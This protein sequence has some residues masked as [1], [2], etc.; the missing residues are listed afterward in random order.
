[1]KQSSNGIINSLPKLLNRQ[2]GI[3]FFNLLVVHHNEGGD[4]SLFCEATKLC[5]ASVCILSYSWRS[6]FTSS[7]KRCDDANTLIYIFYSDIGEVLL[8]H[9]DKSVYC[10]AAGATRH[11]QA[12]QN[13]VNVVAEYFTE[14]VEYFLFFALDSCLGFGL[15]FAGT[16][17]AV[18]IN[19]KLLSIGNI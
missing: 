8:R 5:H 2:F 12:N 4:F 10:S 3:K 18:L 19:K 7:W 14:E 1:M 9:L 15:V 6:R 17:F 13:A 11:T 16:L